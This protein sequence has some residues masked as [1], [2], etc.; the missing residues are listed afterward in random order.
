MVF[1]AVLTH[2]A[3]FSRTGTQCPLAAVRQF[4]S[5]HHGHECQGNLGLF[6]NSLNC[7]I[8]WVEEL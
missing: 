6:I 1:N 8:A 2:V 5:T 7:S 3:F 4:L